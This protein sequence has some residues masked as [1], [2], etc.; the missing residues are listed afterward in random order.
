MLKRQQG[1]GKGDTASHEENM[2]R[3]NKE[4]TVII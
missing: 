2:I 3:A 1:G 4:L